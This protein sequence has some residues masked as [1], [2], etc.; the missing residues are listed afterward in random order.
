[1][2]LTSFRNFDIIHRPYCRYHQL[3][4]CSSI[5]TP[6][7]LCSSST[8]GL[9]GNSHQLDVVNL[10]QAGNTSSLELQMVPDS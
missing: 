6:P 4:H 2:N 7:Y 10:P 5:Q 8:I 1:M 3:T 9:A